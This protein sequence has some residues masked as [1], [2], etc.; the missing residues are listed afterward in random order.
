VNKEVTESIWKDLKEMV[1]VAL[2]ECEKKAGIKV[3]R[4]EPEREDYVNK[5]AGMVYGHLVGEVRMT[6][7]QFI[8]EANKRAEKFS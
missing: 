4:D 5:T 8:V 7:K 6:V 3:G 1:V 2:E